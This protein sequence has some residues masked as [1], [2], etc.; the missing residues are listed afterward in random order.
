[1]SMVRVVH[2]FSWELGEEGE[3]CIGRKKPMFALDSIWYA[4]GVY[5]GQKN[6]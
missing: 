2:V 5:E 1:M 3:S 6:E 4:W